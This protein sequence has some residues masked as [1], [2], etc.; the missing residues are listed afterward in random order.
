MKRI[1]KYALIIIKNNKI[2]LQLEKKQEKLLLPGGKPRKGENYEKCLKREIKEELDAEIKEGSL[3]PLGRFE[4]IA[5]DGK[6]I[7]TAEI[8][9]GELKT[10]PKPRNEVKKLIWFRVK[11]RQDILSPVIRNKIIPYLLAVRLIK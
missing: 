4:D 9:L 2:L 8:Y 11:D 10:T 5:A 7:L 3:K 6:A 1:I